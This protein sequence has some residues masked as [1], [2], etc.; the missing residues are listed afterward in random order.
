MTG[1]LYG[2]Q[3]G[4]AKCEHILPNTD[5]GSVDNVLTL[6]STTRALSDV[7]P[8]D[9]SGNQGALM[10]VGYFLSPDGNFYWMETYGAI[11]TSATTS[12][13]LIGVN[14]KHSDP[15]SAAN[16][17]NSRAPLRG[18]A[19]TWPAGR[20]W[21]G[22]ASGGS[23]IFPH[24]A[25]SFVTSRASARVGTH[26][27]VA[28]TNGLVYYVSYWQEVN[29]FPGTEYNFATQFYGG[30][31]AH[32]TA[33]DDGAQQSGE[34]YA[35][36]T[37]TGAGP[38]RISNLGADSY[39]IYRFVRYIQPSRDGSKVAFISTPSGG[40]GEMMTNS[41]TI[42]AASGVAF[43]A[44]GALS[45]SLARFSVET[46]QGRAGTSMSWDSTGNK[47][48]YAFG[49]SAGNEN[50]MNLVEA[51]LNATGTGVQGKRTQLSTLGGVARFSV[52]N[53][54]R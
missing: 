33:W 22:N 32:P 12:H 24:A 54:G 42:H 18:F 5:G 37:S 45:G 39:N 38:A 1:S 35:M 13:R 34:V 21:G 46:T 40:T 51:T 3:I 15:A 29:S 7:A 9:W 41:E 16:T 31:P 4:A 44:A 10:P 53:A 14:V 49:A 25:F 26:V 36:E 2:Y 8:A 19:P 52:L 30:G 17:I 27:S 28:D 48:F 20:G 50:Q 6:T 23:N 11:S 43:S 47:L